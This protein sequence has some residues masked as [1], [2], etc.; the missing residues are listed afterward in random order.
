MAFLGQIVSIFGPMVASGAQQIFPMIASI[1]TKTVSGISSV[2]SHKKELGP[3][4]AQYKAPGM[5][6]REDFK[7]AGLDPRNGVPQTQLAYALRNPNLNLAPMNPPPITRYAS[8]YARQLG[9][10]FPDVKKT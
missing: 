2:F 10:R 4:G 9:D 5:L 3:G 6:P 8:E 1:L 7:P